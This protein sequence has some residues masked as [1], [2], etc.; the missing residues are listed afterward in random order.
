MVTYPEVQAKAQ[1][2]LDSVLG[3]GHLPSFGDE[4]SLPYLMAT[5]KEVMRWEVVAPFSIP[6]SSTEED[7]YKGFTIPRGSL[8]LPNTWSVFKCLYTTLV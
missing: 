7:V 2:E 1:A 6:H 3:V 5:Y 4:T 8:I